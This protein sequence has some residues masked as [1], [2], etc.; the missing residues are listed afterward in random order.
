MEKGKRNQLDAK[1]R[2]ML[3]QLDQA[4]EKRKHPPVRSGTGNIIRRRDGKEDK[5]FS[6]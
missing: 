2:E 5:R 4:D 1:L 3:R 6:A